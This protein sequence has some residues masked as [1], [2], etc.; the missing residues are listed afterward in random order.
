VFLAT[1]L[2]AWAQLTGAYVP[3]PVPP[4]NF[5]D[6]QRLTDLVRAGTLYLSL[7]DAITLAL[8]NNLDVE[9]ERYEPRKASTDTLRAKG[10]GSLRGIALSVTE[11]PVGIGGPAGP[12]VNAASGGNVSGSSVP[13]GQAELGALAF[14]QSGISIT[15][16]SVFSAGPPVPPFDPTLN[17]GLEYQHQNTPEAN[18]AFSG[19]SALVGNTWSGNFGVQKGFSTGSLLDVSWNASRQENNSRTNQLN[20]SA[21]SSLGLTFT[22]PLLRG[23]GVEMNRRY[24]RIAKNNEKTSTLVFTQQAIATV[25]GVIRLY[26][27]LVSLTEDVKVKQQTLM[28]AQRLYEDNRVAVEQGTLAPVELTRAQAQVA[29]ARQDLANSQG[30]ERQQELIV[31]NVLSRRGTAD[32]TLRSVRV[33]PTTPIEIPEREPVRPIE[34]LVSDAFHNRPELEEAGLQ[35]QNSHISLA[36]SR[37]ALLPQLDLVAT[38]QNA[39]LTGSP[40][41]LSANSGSAAIGSGGESIGGVGTGLWQSLS[42]QHPTYAIGIQL[43]LPLRNRIAQAD[44][45]RDEMQLRQWEIRYQQLQNQVR[46]EVEGAAIALDQART[47]YEA[48]VEARALQEQS[49]TIETEKLAA[50]LS[51]TFLLLQYQS[52]LAQARSTEVAARGVYAK[53]RTSLERAMG[54]T[55]ENHSI[56]INTVYRGR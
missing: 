18:P 56:D 42:A 51:T 44:E 8:E 6:S 3:H 53:A 17:A 38:A 27:D 10:G 41:A 35:I 16:A 46:L 1:A 7:S 11:T 54:R 24:I 39:G 49:L 25:A 32:A 26:D 52:F 23:F 9:Y 55:L 29:A 50:G 13:S 34:D 33:A 21:S 47:A 48:A 22:Q 5:E 40:N 19:A 2:G 4:V 36:G 28:L 15:G 45:A 14:S 20:P 43:S 30:F 37:N 31:K 12:L